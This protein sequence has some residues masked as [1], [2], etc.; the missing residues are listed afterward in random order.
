MFTVKT[1]TSIVTVY[2]YPDVTYVFYVHGGQTKWVTHWR[3]Q[4]VALQTMLMWKKNQQHRKTP[5][6]HTTEH[7]AVRSVTHR[8][9]HRHQT[10]Q[11]ERWLHTGNRFE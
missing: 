1:P 8:H 11:E 5:K 2:I 6:P 7:G 10:R 3:R 4:A 9:T